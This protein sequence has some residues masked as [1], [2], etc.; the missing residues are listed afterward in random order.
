MNHYTLEIDAGDQAYHKTVAA[1]TPGK[2][3][4]EA[5]LEVSDCWDMTFPQFLKM[6]RSCR[7]CDR[8]SSDGY[9]VIERQYGKRFRVGDRVRFNASE[10][11]KYDGVEGD[12]VAPDGPSVHVRVYLPN[13][14]RPVFVHPHSVDVV[15]SPNSEN[16]K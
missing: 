8:P 16:S 4:Y 5:F 15:G 13:H 10:G 2:A 6:V 1:L 9:D 11:P 3:K 14:E 12:V 7:L